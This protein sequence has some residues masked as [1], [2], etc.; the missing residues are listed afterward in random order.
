MMMAIPYGTVEQTKFKAYA[1]FFSSVVR[2]FSKVM[3]VGPSNYLLYLNRSA[4]YTTFDKY[5]E[6]LADVVKT[7]QLKPG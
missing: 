3:S 7:V 2:H 4:T 6:A 1:A 5:S